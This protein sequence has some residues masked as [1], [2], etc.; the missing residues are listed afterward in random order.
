MKKYKLLKIITSS[1]G[2]V[3]IVGIGTTMVVACGKKSTETA[4]EKF[5]KAAKVESANNIVTNAKPA[6]ANWENLSA[7]SGDLSIK[8]VISK[9]KVVTIIVKSSSK[10]EVA[11]FSATYTGSAYTDS[12]WVCSQAPSNSD[13]ATHSWL[14]FKTAAAKDSAAQMFSQAS[15]QKTTWKTSDKIIKY[16]SPVNDDSAKTVTITLAD[17]PKSETVNFVAT[18]TTNRSYQSSDWAST[19]TP[20]SA[21]DN[22]TFKKIN[23]PNPTVGAPGTNVKVKFGKIIYLGGIGGLWTSI[24]DED[25]VKNNSITIPNTVEITAIIKIGTNIFIGTQELQNYKQDSNKAGLFMSSDGLAFTQVANNIFNQNV[26]IT[27]LLDVNGTLFIGSQYGLVSWDTKSTTSKTYSKIVIGKPDSTI[28]A[29]IHTLKLIDNKIFVG[30]E[31]NGLWRS[32]ATKIAF[33]KININGAE[34]KAASYPFIN[35][36][37]A[38]NKNIYIFISNKSGYDD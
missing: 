19:Q 36:I 4:L 17:L 13:G 24:D 32:D 8:S 38:I 29:T 1:L 34:S 2:V 26:I 21:K 30:T 27:S 33:T 7:K 10:S 16:T 12:V 9:G 35:L 3:G 15:T 23:L 11:T 28:L 18:Y 31:T 20:V 5:I 25:W 37:K 6:A 14:D 22:L